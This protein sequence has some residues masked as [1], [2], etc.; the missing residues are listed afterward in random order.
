MKEEMGRVKT[1][2]VTY[3]V[4][5]TSLNGFEIHE[6]DIM[7]IGDKGILADGKDIEEVTLQMLEAMVDDESCVISIYYGQDVDEAAAS[8]L[9]DKV[10]ALYPDLDVEVHSGGQ[11]IYYYLVSVE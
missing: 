6:G 5:D 1:S 3:A 11:P 9:E 2:E 7:G 4:R 10:Q 8:A